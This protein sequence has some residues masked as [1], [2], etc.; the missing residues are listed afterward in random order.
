MPFNGSGIYT[1]PSGNPVTTGTPILSSTTNTT[2]SDLA[3][4]LS[5]CMTRDGQSPPTVNI[6]M[7]GYRLTGL[8]AGVA[9]GDSVR[10]EQVL[11]LSGGIMTGTVTLVTPVLGTPTSGTLTNCTGS[12]A[13]CTADGTNAV[14][15]KNVPQSGADKT[16]AYTLATTD[17]GKFIGIGSSGSIVVPNSTF[18]NGDAISLF[19]NTAGNVTI[20]LNTTS[21]YLSGTATAKTSVTLLARGVATVLFYSGTVCIVTGSVI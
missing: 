5:N 16:T 7:G 1:L 9:A 11:L 20:T 19:N 8:A 14:G 15:F 3:T 10:Y 21:T 18:A 12:L 4:A 2:N 17:V 13:N 6:P